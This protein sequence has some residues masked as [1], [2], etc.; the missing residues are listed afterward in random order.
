MQTVQARLAW[1]IR[2]CHHAVCLSHQGSFAH[3]DGWCV[4]SLWWWLTA[5]ATA[6]SFSANCSN[7]HWPGCV[8]VQWDP[9]RPHTPMLMKHGDSSLV[10]P[11]VLLFGAV[12]ASS[13]SLAPSHTAFL[14]RFL[15]CR[16]LEKSA[17]VGRGE[18]CGQVCILAKPVT[19]MN[20]S[21]ESV[22][23]LAQFYKVR[24]QQVTA[25]VQALFPECRT[26]VGPSGTDH[27]TCC[28]PLHES[29][30]ATTRQHLLRG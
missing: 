12:F 20:N 13:E 23:A 22:A 9:D 24:T 19:F 28:I 30:S 2:V 1:M 17:A 11:L 3:A 16:K 29:D 18:V 7:C 26:C 27:L 21:G 25:V 15:V 6:A 10:L 4:R 14:S 5:G 8:A